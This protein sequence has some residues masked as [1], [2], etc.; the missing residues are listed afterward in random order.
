MIT[1]GTDKAVSEIIETDSVLCATSFFSDVERERIKREVAGAQ[2][3]RGAF[4]MSRTVHVATGGACRTVNS[5]VLSPVK[6]V[7][8]SLHIAP[9]ESREYGFPLIGG[10]VAIVVL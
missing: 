3:Q 8:Q 9:P 10:A 7:Q 1:V 4:R 6:T 2:R 5:S